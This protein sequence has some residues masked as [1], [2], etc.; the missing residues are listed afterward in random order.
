MGG[1]GRGEGGTFDEVC[2]CGWCAEAGQA[3]EVGEG[4]VCDEG[5]GAGGGGGGGPGWGRLGEGGWRIAGEEGE[6][7]EVA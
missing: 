1:G 7:M 4:P 5:R 6:G 3:A 2:E